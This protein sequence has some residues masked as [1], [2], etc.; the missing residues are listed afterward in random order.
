MAALK[1]NLSGPFSFDDVPATRAPAVRE[2]LS[3]GYGLRFSTKIYGANGR[4]QFSTNTYMNI[5]LLQKSSNICGNLKEFT[6]EW[7][8]GILYS[9]SLLRS[10]PAAR[11]Q[12]GLPVQQ[13]FWQSISYSDF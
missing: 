5:V 8:L 3:T 2:Y 12:P 1:W 4:K 9:S 13:P 10:P 7:N 11:R 6:G